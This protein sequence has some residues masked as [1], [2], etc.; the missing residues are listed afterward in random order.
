MITKT[1]K[2]P[3]CKNQVTIQGNPREKIYVT[4]PKCNTRG[5]FTYPEETFFEKSNE[6][7][8]IEVKNL[9]K[10]YNGFKAVDNLAFNIKQGEIF[11]FLGPNGAGKTTTIRAMLGLINY[12]GQ[13]KINGLDI[14]TNEKETKKYIGYLPERV[15]FYNNLTAL[16]NLRFYSEI[17]NISTEESLHFLEEFGLSESMHMK[18]GK[19]SKGMVQ[20]LGFIRAINGNP[21]ILILDEP[22]A[23]LDAQSVVLVREKLR[24]L[25]N[26]RGITIFISSHVLSE[27]QQVCDRVGIINKGVLVAQDTI[28][29]LSKKL[30][31][32]PRIII[33][34]KQISNAIIE[35]VKSIKGVDKIE[36]T[37]NTMEIMC[38][39]ETRSQIIVEIEKAG[40]KIINLQTKEPSLEEVFISYTE[41]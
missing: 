5:E 11:G 34:V 25:N 32:K 1:V 36:T 6:S 4:C 3:N 39:P 33:T 35:A 13:I 41:G 19:F 2:C 40:G 26:R 30:Q 7:Y 37:K 28:S 8:L 9:T 22:T 29:E 18:V 15:A 21:T 31:I 38:N 23:G 20:K 12:S 24:E 17:K 10:F 27:I 14:K 16:Q